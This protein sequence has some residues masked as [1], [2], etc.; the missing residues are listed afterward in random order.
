[1]PGWHSLFWKLIVGLALFCLLTVSMHLDLEQRV[2]ES[3]STLSANSRQELSGF[4]REA[5]TA[6]RERGRTGMDEFLQ[7]LYQREQ[8]WVVAVD[9]K[10]RS[11]SSTPLNEEEAL[12]LSFVR[13]LDQKVG[14]P[15]GQPVFYVPFSD[16]NGRLVM[17]LPPRLDPRNDSSLWD[18]FLRSVLPACLAILL[19]TLLYRWLIAPLVILRRQANSLSAGDLSARVGAPVASRQDEL[20]ELGRAF[21]HMAERLQGT[22]VYQRRLLRDLSHELRT[23]LSRLRVASDGESDPQVLRQR[24]DREITI[25]QNLVENSLE[26]AWLDSE[27]PQFARE[28]IRVLQLWDMLVED[29][30]FEAGWSG[31][32]LLFEVDEDCTVYANLTSLAQALENLLRNAIRHSPPAGLVRLTGAREDDCWHL[33]LGDDGPGIEER[34]LETIFEPFARL[35]SARPGDGGFGLGLSIARSAIALQGGRLWAQSPPG[36]GLQMHLLLPAAEVQEQS[37]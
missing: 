30:C 29:A 26:L 24:L 3:M 15:G 10:H 16:G 27:R 21:D 9:A 17:E 14:R 37:V 6:W 12:R 33:C 2:Y 5:E 4:A 34:Y 32:R 8:V 1:M 36:S 25:M 13:R 22:V 19:G 23:P 7:D 18:F 11:L 28:P 31:E 35:D 20:G